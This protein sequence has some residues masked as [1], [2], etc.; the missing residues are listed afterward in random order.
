MIEFTMD[1]LRAAHRCCIRNREA[2]EKSTVCGCFYCMET[3]RPS[4]VTD[5]VEIENTAL[6]PRCGIDAVLGDH[7]GLPVTEPEFLRAM[8]QHW[9]ER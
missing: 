6:C 8:H 1:Q 3:Y 2:L 9:F 4:E 5:W 7:T